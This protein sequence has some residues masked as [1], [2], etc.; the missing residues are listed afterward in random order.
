MV[1]TIDG[2]NILPYIEENGIKW[3]R[4]DVE[5]P[6]AGRALNA[7]MYRGR[8]AVKVRLDISCRPLIS[9]EA[10]IVLRAIHPE[11][12]TVQYED[13]LQGTV[14]SKQMYSNNVPA[15]CATVYPDGTAV[16]EDISFPLIER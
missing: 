1:F 4:N 6:D 5:S 10:R 16:W 2:V 11:Y 14:V 3:Q 7:T 12:V 9:R 15:T 13:P 8:V